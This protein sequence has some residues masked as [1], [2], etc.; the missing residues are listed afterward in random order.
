MSRTNLILHNPDLLRAMLALGE[1]D[2]YEIEKAR[3]VYKEQRERHDAFLEA[4]DG[5][6]EVP[7]ALEFYLGVEAA[8]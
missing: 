1:F 7:T 5:G 4:V 3:K 8:Q 2:G 6:V